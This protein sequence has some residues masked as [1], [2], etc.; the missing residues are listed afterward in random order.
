MSWKVATCKEADGWNAEVA[1]PL[2]SIG[3]TPG[4]PIRLHLG[5]GAK[6]LAEDSCWPLVING[7]FNTSESFGSIDWQE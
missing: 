1:I 7:S 3:L 4:A 5:R 6:T 2:Q